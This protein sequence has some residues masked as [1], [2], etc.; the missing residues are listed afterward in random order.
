[1][2]LDH[3]R[4]SKLSLLNPFADHAVKP[5]PS[6]WY[7]FTADSVATMLVAAYF[8]ALGNKL[9]VDDRIWI[10]TVDGHHMFKV[11]AA[12]GGPTPSVTVAAI[13]GNTAKGQF[14]TVTAVD[15]VVTG[16]AGALGGV[17]VSFNDDLTADPEFVTGSIGNQAGAP[18]AG[19]F[20][21]KT[22]KTAAGPVAA[23]T[24]AKKV[25]W[26]AWQ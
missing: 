19:S 7:Y 23:T 17:L 13:V 6:L 4:F 8:S 18:A 24:F 20:L 15:T 26:F 22:W 14:A 2:A 10:E 11:T 3:N 1:M 9:Q 25:N 5:D 16:L 21:L 12:L